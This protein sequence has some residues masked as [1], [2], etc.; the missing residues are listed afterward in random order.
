MNNTEQSE[1]PHT[2][3]PWAYAYN[4]LGSHVVYSTDGSG[5]R[6]CEMQQ[7]SLQANAE[8]IARAPELAAEVSALKAENELLR[9]KADNWDKLEPNKKLMAFYDGQSKFIENALRDELKAAREENLNLRAALEPFTHMSMMDGSLVNYY[10][11]K[12]KAALSKK[13]DA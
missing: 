12:A 2:P 8:L 9:V 5:T 13:P 3:G 6:I 1:T 11:I 7:G 4:G 10:I